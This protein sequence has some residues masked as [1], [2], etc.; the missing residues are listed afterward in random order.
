MAE[1]GKQATLLK[2][3]VIG[4]GGATAHSRGI[5]RVYDPI[6]Q[7]IG[8]AAEGLKFWKGFSINYPSVFKKSGVA[9]FLA[10]QNVS[11]AKLFYLQKQHIPAQPS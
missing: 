7:I 4:G 2:A 3:N 6:P 11:A 5:V 9:Y 8:Y 1:A 10:P